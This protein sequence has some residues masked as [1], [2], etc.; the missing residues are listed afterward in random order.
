MSTSTDVTTDLVHA[1]YDSWQNG[2][3]TLDEARLRSILD[4][5]LQF[6]GPIAGSRTGVEPFMRGLADFVRSVKAMRMLQQ[7]QAPNAAASLYDCDLG[8]TAGAL[9]FAEFIR[10]ENGRI[11]TITLVYDPA[12][13]R[14]LT[15]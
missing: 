4:P 9:R 14:R 1:Y 7:V 15:A 13:F 10:I 6:E 12:E 2:I 5:D 3:A 11:K 8:V